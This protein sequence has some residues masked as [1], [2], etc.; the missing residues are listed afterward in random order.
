MI[1]QTRLAPQYSILST[2]RLIVSGTQGPTEKLS[3]FVG[4]LLQPIAKQQKSYLKDM[5]TFI[6]F[7]EKTKIPEK[8]TLVSMDVTS[9]Y[10]NKLQDEGIK[11]ICRSYTSFYQNKTSIPTCENSFQLNGKNYLKLENVC[12]KSGQL[13]SG[14]WVLIK[15]NSKWRREARPTMADYNGIEEA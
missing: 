2:G 13:C 5:T 15:T 12:F 7:I 14:P 9:L 6:D 3:A 4:R 10:S 11:T 1:Y 8:A